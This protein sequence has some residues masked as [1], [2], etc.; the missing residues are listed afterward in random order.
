MGVMKK[1]VFILILLAMGCSGSGGGAEDSEA[2][3]ILSVSYDK[4]QTVDGIVYQRNEPIIWTICFFDEQSDVFIMEMQIYDPYD[5]GPVVLMLRFD[6]VQNNPTDCITANAGQWV[7]MDD[8][9]WI[10]SHYWFFAWRAIDSEGNESFP[11]ET[12][13]LIQGK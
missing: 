7:F 10:P 12:E 13:L 4:E 1:L 9:P 8:Y 3:Q 2:P 6:V 11:H 5:F